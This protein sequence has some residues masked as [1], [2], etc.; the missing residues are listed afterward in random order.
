MPSQPDAVL[1]AVPGRER[2]DS[3][4]THFLCSLGF[5]PINH[6]KC[7]VAVLFFLSAPPLLLILLL[8]RHKISTQLLHSTIPFPPMLSASDPGPLVL[9]GQDPEHLDQIV[10]R[11]STN[12]GLSCN[13][14]STKQHWSSKLSKSNGP[15]TRTWWR[16]RPRQNGRWP[17]TPPHTTCTRPALTCKKPWQSAG[18]STP[19]SSSSV[20]SRFGG[21]ADGGA[22]PV[23]VRRG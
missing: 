13:S 14:S 16:A 8:E 4:L 7:A 5:P 23:L 6:A 17:S 2:T 15:A 19:V 18:E 22:R 9:L 20:V 10:A 1:S 12:F 3:Q 11:M 21:F